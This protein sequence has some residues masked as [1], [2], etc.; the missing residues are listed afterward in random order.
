M[1][2]KGVSGDG[3][4][5]WELSTVNLGNESKSIKALLKQQRKSTLQFA[6]SQEFIYNIYNP[7]PVKV[8]EGI[9]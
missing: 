4:G 5:M 9:F 8:S 7:L 6:S 2:T 3:R 1:Q